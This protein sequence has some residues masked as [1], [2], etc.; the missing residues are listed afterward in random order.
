MG[1]SARQGSPS[2]SRS[3]LPRSANGKHA[4]VGQPSRP[5]L[6]RRIYRSPTV[7]RLLALR[8]PLQLGRLSSL[9]VA[10]GIEL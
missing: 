3:R 2:L 6:Q 5:L 9:Q 10:L 8:L 7:S 4:H 1:Y